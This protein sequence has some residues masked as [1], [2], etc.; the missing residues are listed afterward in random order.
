MIT[1][2]ALGL[3]SGSSLDGLD[4]ALCRFRLD[5]ASSLPVLEWQLLAT[6]TAAFDPAWRERL[7]ALPKADGRTL[8]RA[9]ADFGHYLGRL[10]Q[11]FLQ[12]CQTR[13]DLI[14]SH[15][16]TIF[17][18]PDQ[19]FTLQIGDGAALAAA[20]GCTVIDNFRA[21]DIA[22][23]GQGAPLAPLADRFLFPGYDFY[24]NLGGIANISCNAG[25]RFVAFDIGGANQVLNALVEPMG[26][27]Y[28]E[29]GRI[30][31]S[32]HLDTGLLARADAL[33]YFRQ[34]YPKSLGNDWVQER[35]LPIYLEASA[36]TADK[37][38]TAGIQLARQ[39]AAAITRIL[40]RES[41][42]KQHYRLLATGGG[43]F[44]S[45]LLNAIREEGSKVCSLE[46]IAPGPEIIG[47]K[48]AA[49]MALMGALRY[50]GLPNCLASATGASQ[51][52]SGGAI[53]LGTNQKP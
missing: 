37:L 53:H 12:E 27:P 20:T 17:H 10:V 34:P 36:T 13:P 24:L 32:G 7:R 22:L 2:H 16:H 8:M 5:P 50:H 48:E 30:A 42:G 43:A 9:H 26:L 51:D 35:L 31:A 6:R 52:A 33:P 49:L 47:F 44:N 41:P 45:F 25:D 38:H 29:D 15:G 46:I 14:A 19:G 3:M 23:G 40:E 39:T 18:Y 1:V 4:M 28:D 21:L 11:P